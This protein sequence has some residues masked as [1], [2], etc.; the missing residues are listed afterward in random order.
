MALCIILL[1]VILASIFKH[2]RRYVKERIGG[3]AAKKESS[4]HLL[5]SR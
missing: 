3:E 1:S 5:K 4:A 2:G